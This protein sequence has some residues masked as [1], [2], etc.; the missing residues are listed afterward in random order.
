M[1]GFPFACN[2][3][4]VMKSFLGL[5]VL[6]FFFPPGEEGILAFLRSQ[7]RGTASEKDKNNY[8][9]IINLVS[10]QEAME[11]LLQKTKGKHMS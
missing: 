8:Y 5:S 6:C 4:S 9:K 2:L 11:M 1:V 10:A 3:A 7:L